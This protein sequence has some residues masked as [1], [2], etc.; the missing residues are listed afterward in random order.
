MRCWQ[1]GSSIF[2]QVERGNR[3]RVGELLEA[4]YDCLEQA[5]LAYGHG[6]EGPL[7][8]AAHLIA[9]VLFDAPTLSEAQLNE[10]VNE[11]SVD[12]LEQIVNRPHRSGRRQGFARGFAG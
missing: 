4:V 1:G 7:D 3:L 2:N 9:Q 10:V 8:E 11:A 5:G 6:M 12:Q